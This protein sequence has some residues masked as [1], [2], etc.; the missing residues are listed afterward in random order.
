MRSQS[1]QFVTVRSHC[2]KLALIVLFRSTTD[3]TLATHSVNHQIKSVVASRFSYSSLRPAPTGGFGRLLRVSW[4]TPLS[5]LLPRRDILIKRAPHDA[6]ARLKNTPAAA[7]RSRAA[8]TANFG[9]F[10][11][12]STLTSEWTQNVNVPRMRQGLEYLYS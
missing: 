1:D 4:L 9:L 5:P 10:Q 2:D 3:E 8:M 6:S 11:F 7:L 12:V